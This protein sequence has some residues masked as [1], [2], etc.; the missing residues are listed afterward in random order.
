VFG[1]LCALASEEL[2]DP[3]AANA[4]GVAAATRHAR[5][6]SCGHHA[7]EEMRVPPRS[8]VVFSHLRWDSVFQRPHHIVTRLARRRP[9]WFIEEPIARGDGSGLDLATVAPNVVRCQLRI[10]RARGF[11][12][13]DVPELASQLSEL[14]RL[15]APPRAAWLYTP[16]ALPLARLLRPALIAY[17]C[18]DELSAFLFAPPALLEWEAELLAAAGVVFTGGRSL[19]DAKRRRHANVHCMPSSVERAHFHAATA[20]A[21]ADDQAALPRPRLGFY[22][23]IDERL[24][25]PLLD[26]VAAARP[27][28]QFVMV[29]PVVKIDPARLPRHPNLHWL[30]A[31]PY[32]ALPRYLAGW[33]VC[34][35]PFARNDATRFISPTK[36]LEYMAAERPIVSTS[37]RDVAEP[38]GDIVY[39]GDTPAAFTAACARA[40]SAADAERRAR[41]ERMRSV[42]ET[43]SWDATAATMY[44]A[45]L[46]AQAPRQ[47]TVARPQ[48]SA[49]AAAV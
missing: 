3:R 21:D 16:M 2:R 19:Y 5:H 33:D 45:L 29:G 15:I 18:M 11:D 26:A 22:G 27:Q 31:R 35:M 42:V 46:K 1:K 47:Q 14:R 10:G 32:D 9:V 4:G 17:D 49:V 23:V 13:D 36:T 43:T 25:L 24:D 20:L 28:W 44:A 34:L 6:G 8:I 40:L 7:P 38:Y 39:L 41:I 48:P 37:I 30:G 12:P